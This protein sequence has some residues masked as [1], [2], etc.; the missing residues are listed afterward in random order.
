MTFADSRMENKKRIMHENLFP[1]SLSDWNKA[2]TTNF[3]FRLNLC[4]YIITW[5]DPKSTKEQICV[6]INKNNNKNDNSGMK[7]TISKR[8][9]HLD[10]LL[11]LFLYFVRYHRIHSYEV[12]KVS[13]KFEL[14]WC[15]EMVLIFHCALLWATGR[16]LYW[17]ESWNGNHKSQC[18]GNDETMR[19]Q[20]RPQ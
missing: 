14:M 16:W 15:V 1:L 4:A 6:S 5:G 17:F 10:K 9:L 11:L 7:Y 20:D 13:H 18:W 3:V 2:R 12:N 19:L 8:W